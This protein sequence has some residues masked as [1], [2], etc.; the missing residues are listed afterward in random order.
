MESKPDATPDS[1]APTDSPQP[2]TADFPEAADPTDASA[3]GGGPEDATPSSEA[4]MP[5]PSALVAMAAMHMP[6]TDLIHVLISVFDAHAWRSMGLVADHSGEVRKDLP[7]AQVSIDCLAFLLG[8][9]ESSLDDAEKRDVQRRL[10]D[11]R[12]NYVAKMR[13]C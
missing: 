10:M 3:T 7:S 1:Q 8:K 5:D 12:M 13:E 2:E 9:V 11:L 4:Q 6:T